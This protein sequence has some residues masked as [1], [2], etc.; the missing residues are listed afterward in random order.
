MKVKTVTER[1]QAV[2]EG[3]MA[4]REFVRQMRNEYPMHI[5]QFNGFNDS[6]Q[7]LKN[8]GLLFEAKKQNKKAKQYDD[9]PALSYSLDALDRGIRAE[10]QINGIAFIEAEKRAK[11]NLE[12][13]PLHYINLLSGES[14]KVDKHDKMKE[15]K[16]G[17]KDKDTY[18]DLKKATLKE[19]V[20]EAGPSGFGTGQGR[21][22]TI[23]KG[24]EERP[25]IKAKQASA[26]KKAPKYVMKNGVPHKFDANGNLVPLKKVS[27]SPAGNLELK[28]VAKQLYQRFKKLGADVTL[29]TSQKSVNKAPE[30]GTG[31][32]W[33]L[34]QKNVWIYSSDGVVG[35]DLVG[36]K[37]ASFEDTIRQEFSKFKFSDTFK[38]KSW[39]GHDVHSF[40]IT[41]GANTSEQTNLEGRLREALSDPAKLA[42]TKA[43]KAK[44]PE[45]TAGILDVFFDMHGDDISNG[46]DPL[47]E[48]TEFFYANF[49]TA[50]DFRD[51]DE[52]KGKDHDGDGDIDGDDYKAAKDKAIKKAMGK[53]VNENK[54]KEAITSIIKKTLNEEVIN[55]AAT[56]R[57]AAKLEDL[58]IYPGAQQVINQLENIVTEVESFY[59]KTRDKIQKVYDSMESIENEEGLK[60]GVFIGPGIESAFL[61]DLKPVTRKGFTQDLNLPKAKQ[62][63]P[64]MIA[65]AR[66]AGEIDEAPEEDKQTVFTPNI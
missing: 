64:E 40:N 5:T 30:N 14:S 66:A 9:R 7:I 31:D 6:V 19:A 52:A 20:N 43:I 42:A 65:Q 47:G 26:V 10:L 11:A 54:L 57:L 60:I 55:E 36:D 1:Y 61:Q 62:L 8:R 28:S 53:D 21:S 13:D 44:Y 29:G 16:R 17:A 48:F 41:P 18:N 3:T 59:G 23:S 33:G 15:T 24:R 25:D 22:K 45:V 4:K 63:D 39:N 50:S 58:K 37:A 32:K 49:E 46:E 51:V 38:S 34:D 35:V 2:L 27:E 12:K 56:N